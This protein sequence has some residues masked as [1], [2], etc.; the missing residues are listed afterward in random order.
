MKSLNMRIV[1]KA[2]IV[3]M[4]SVI[5]INTAW[6]EKEI[7]IISP[8]KQVSVL[9]SVTNE[10]RLSYAIKSN[11]AQVL[12]TSPLGIVVDGIDLGNGAKIVSKPAYTR[13][14]ENYAILGNHSVAY[15]RCNEAVI[16][17]ETVGKAYKLIVRVYNDGVGIRY[18]LPEGSKHIDREN[19]SWNLPEKTKKVVWLDFSQCYEELSYVTALEKI[20]QD[21][22]VMGPITFEV[23]GHFLSISEADCETFSDMAFTRNDNLLKATFPFAKDGWDIGR[24]TDDRVTVLAGTYLGYQVSPKYFILRTQHV[25]ESLKER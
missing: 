13:I 15:N 18:T 1:S 23:E 9:V 5:G 19:T 16:P 4:F 14:D 21:K 20:P 6:G 8:N 22:P 10:G 24:R 11:G 17:I 7:K 2:I 12:E 25:R 3:L